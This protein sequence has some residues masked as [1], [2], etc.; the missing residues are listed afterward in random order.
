MMKIYDPDPEIGAVFRGLEL[1]INEIRSL[2]YKKIIIEKNFVYR[3]ALFVLE[4]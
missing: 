4:F 1:F 3:M 2:N